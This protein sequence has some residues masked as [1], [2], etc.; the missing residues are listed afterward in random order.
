M[1]CGNNEIYSGCGNDGCQQR[2]DRLDVTGC[3][4]ICG[5]PACI[6]EEGFVRNAFGACVPVSECRKYYIKL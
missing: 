6:C 2:C 4:P 3:T 1:N 5:A